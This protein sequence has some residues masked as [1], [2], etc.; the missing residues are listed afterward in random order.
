M[1]DPGRDTA[2]SVHKF[3]LFDA[4]LGA[5]AGASLGVLGLGVLCVPQLAESWWLWGI[6][7]YF[8]GPLGVVVVLVSLLLLLESAGDIFLTVEVHSSGLIWRRL[9]KQT[10]VDWEEIKSVSSNSNHA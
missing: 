10:A 9:G 2:V 6:A 4:I 8:C 1:E 7:A 3:R 5:V